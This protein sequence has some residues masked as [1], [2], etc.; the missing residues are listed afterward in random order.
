[1]SVPGIDVSKWQG[2]IDWS[3]A[4][5]AG[6][7][8]AIIRAGSITSVAGTCYEDFQ[9]QRNAELAPQHMPVGFYWY[10]R[11]NWS[12]VKQAEFFI[13]LIKDKTWHIYPVIDVEEKGGQTKTQVEDQVW[14]FCNRVTQRL[15]TPTM[16]YTSPGFWNSY[17][18]R[19]TWAQDI[20]LWVA[21]WNVEIPRLPYDWANYGATYT[22]WQTHVGQDGPEYGMGS[23]GLD[24]DVYNGDWDA[25]QQQFL[26]E[27][28]P[29]PPPPPDETMPVDDF[30]IEKL[31]P[32][33]VE[34]WGYDG[35][36]PV[37]D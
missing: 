11:P 19:N 32:L 5:E 37:K 21:H 8:F 2:E 10:F 18:A 27:E 30:V 31:Y 22:F 29:P 3:K 7:K 33:M 25:F 15:E 4:A 6:A 12:A 35:P 1:M 24:H 13:N 20:P 26:G 14:L 9:F 34:H 23:K 17:V 28:P 36:R 16:I